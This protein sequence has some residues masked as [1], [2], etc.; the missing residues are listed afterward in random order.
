M[1]GEMI[2]M[3]TLLA[4][5]LFLTRSFQAKICLAYNP[6]S[7]PLMVLRTFVLLIWFWGEKLTL[8]GALSALIGGPNAWLTQGILGYKMQRKMLRIGATTVSSIPL[9]IPPYSVCWHR[10]G[11]TYCAGT[12]HGCVVLGFWALKGFH[13]HFVVSRFLIEDLGLEVWLA[14]VVATGF[15]IFAWAVLMVPCMIISLFYSCIKFSYTLAS[16][17]VDNLYLCYRKYGKRYLLKLG[18][19]EAG[20]ENSHVVSLPEKLLL[21]YLHDALSYSPRGPGPFHLNP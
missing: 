20:V 19:C 21:Q 8:E 12:S 9:D 3:L 18:L 11:C 1:G 13:A 7:L 5:L 6:R 17:I 15:I 10:F 4:R 14:W 16:D 2:Q